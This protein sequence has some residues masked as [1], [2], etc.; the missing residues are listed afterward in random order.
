MLTDRGSGQS[1]RLADLIALVYHEARN[2]RHLI[3]AGFIDP[4]PFTHLVSLPVNRDEAWAALQDYRTAALNAKSDSEAAMVF[5]RRFGVSLAELAAVYANDRWRNS[6]YGGNAWFAITLKVADLL[7]LGDEDAA[8]PTMIE[9]IAAM[10]HNT[11]TIQ[12][13]LE[14][15]DS[16]LST[17]Q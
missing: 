17:S 5:E 8:A 16:R 12:E 1:V 6:A 7:E 14:R 11:G 13:K 2:V 10:R 9:E 15:L 3:K 4:A